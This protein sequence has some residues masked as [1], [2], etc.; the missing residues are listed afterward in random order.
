MPFDTIVAGRNINASTMRNR[1]KM[2]PTSRS[3]HAGKRANHQTQSETN[4]SSQTTGCQPASSKSLLQENAWEGH[5]L[6]KRQNHHRRHREVSCS[7]CKWH[8]GSQGVYPTILRDMQ[9][10]TSQRIIV[11]NSQ[12]FR[13]YHRH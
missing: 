10:N 12:S 2:R 8:N 4:R 1:S 6:G 7:A 5:R 13:P 9:S 3:S 11:Q